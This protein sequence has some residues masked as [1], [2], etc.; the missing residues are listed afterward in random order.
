MAASILAPGAVPATRPKCARRLFARSRFL[1]ATTLALGCTASANTGD[2]LRSFPAPGVGGRGIAFDGTLLYYTSPAGGSAIYKCTTNGQPMG[3]IAIETGYESVGGPLAWDGQDLWTLDYDANSFQ[4]LRVDP[5]T[6]FVVSSCD[7]QAV[8]P[9]H[10]A[11]PGIGFYPDGLGWSRSSSTL[12]LSSEAIAGNWVALLDM[13][14]TITSAFQPVPR[15]GAGTSGVD[16]G[17][18]CNL[19]H[20]F[21]NWDVVETGTD[22]TETGLQFIGGLYTEDL[23]YDDITFAPLCALWG[24]SAD[25]VIQAY[26]V[27]CSGCTAPP[28][29]LVSWWPFDASD[30]D[31]APDIV[32]DNDAAWEQEGQSF[33]GPPFP[34]SAGRVGG[35]YRF[36]HSGSGISVAHDPSLDFGADVDLTIDAWINVTGEGNPYGTLPIIMQASGGGGFNVVLQ[37]EA[38]GQY[39][40]AFDSGS[41][42]FLFFGLDPEVVTDAQGII[43]FGVWKLITLTIDRNGEGRFYVNGV[44][45]TGP[46]NVF[47][48]QTL[49]NTD[50]D[51]PGGWRIGWGQT[52]PVNMW[53]EGFIDEVEVFRRVLAEQEITELYGAGCTGK[54]RPG[55]PSSAGTAPERVGTVRFLL[56]QPNPFRDVVDVRFEVPASG[57]VEVDVYDVRGRRIVTLSKG[58]LS[59][60]RHTKSWDGRLAG[61][62]PAPSG[63]YFVSIRSAHGTVS[64]R[65]ILLR[66]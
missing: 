12:V 20:A 43:P 47:D 10:P 38:D 57:P 66:P 36:D 23:A 9:S 14:C 5:A 29:D 65:V 35:A 19:W 25:G 40:L 31:I 37:K 13:D 34:T 30:S 52:A 11:V 48:A 42:Q 33:V 58:T 45:L 62:G 63:I 61:G 54:C 6:G 50:F 41:V 55:T 17:A 56:A 21:L 15:A 8:N 53:F 46:Q 49:A 22:G 24:H 32:G 16:E 2:V 39:H 51:A 59:A 1:A 64:E 7:I 26:E 27:P 3:A 18:N 60:G 28:S 44:P 4:L